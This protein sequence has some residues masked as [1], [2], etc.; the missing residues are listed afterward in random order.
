M[1]YIVMD[2]EWNQGGPA[3]GQDSAIPFEIVEIGAVRLDEAGVRTGAFSCLIRPVV[4]HEMHQI[5]GRLIHLQMKELEKG[6]PFR[7]VAK[8]FLRWCGE[9]YLFCSWGSSDLTELQRNMEYH[10]MAPLAEGPIAYLDVQKLFS[11]A[12]EDGKSRKALKYAVDFL[13]L[14]TDIPFHRALSDAHYT[15]RILE[16][17]LEE[18]PEILRNLSYDVFHPPKDR[19]SEIKVRFE[20]Y[21]K[22]ISREFASKEEAFADREA[23]SSRCYLCHRNL[24]KKIRWFTPNGRHYFCLAYCDTH[25]YL[26]GKI[27]I[28]KSTGEKV[29]IVKTTKLIAPED[30]EALKERRKHTN[31]LHREREQ[32][33]KRVKNHN[34]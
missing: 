11:L 13:Q 12:F 29:Y 28:H 15:A 17:I 31:E 16:K 14:E 19:K 2:L 32:R 26:K 7:E 30:A 34:R 27:R 33:K 1:N 23:A 10:R 5:T 6:K 18:R 25:G 24:R 3:S 22:Y 21:E 9:K 4:Y 8:D 20:N